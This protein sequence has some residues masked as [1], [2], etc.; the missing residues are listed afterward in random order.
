MVLVVA[1]LDSIV[2]ISGFQMAIAQQRIPQSISPPELSGGAT[3]IDTSNSHHADA[4]NI[5][6]VN[7]NARQSELTSIIV[8]VSVH[9][10]TPQ[11]KGRVD[12]IVNQTLSMLQPIG[13]AINESHSCILEAV[14]CGNSNMTKGTMLRL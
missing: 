9:Y 2:F 3:T 11:E 13:R 12:K 10:P 4:A 1:L 14:I 8:E 6:H 7:K 5:V